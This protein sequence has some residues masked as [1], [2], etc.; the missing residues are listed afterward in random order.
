MCLSNLP[1]S[2]RIRNPCV[3]IC[4]FCIYQSVYTVFLLYTDPANVAANQAS[5]EEADSRSVFVGN[6]RNMI[7]LSSDALLF[8]E[9]M[10]AY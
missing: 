3:S 9:V 8:Q 4:F 10:Y 6:V 7:H 5:K 1:V 2:S